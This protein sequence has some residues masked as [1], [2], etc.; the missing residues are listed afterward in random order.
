MGRRETVEVG[1]F[2]LA[3][4]E[5]RTVG[6]LLCIRRRR[7]PDGEADDPVFVYVARSGSKE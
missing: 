1:G 7:S 4:Q 2:F 5:E 3:L 6:T